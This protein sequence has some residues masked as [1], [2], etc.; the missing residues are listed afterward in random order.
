MVE[1]FDRQLE[2]IDQRLRRLARRQPG[3]RALMGH[4]GIG[5]LLAPTILSELGDVGR[6]SASRKA[7]CCAGLD[8]SAQRSCGDPC[9]VV[10]C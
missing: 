7:V 1:A 2:A 8:E 4:F 5:E 3:C 6:L 9:L 10:L